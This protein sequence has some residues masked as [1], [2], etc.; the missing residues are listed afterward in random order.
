EEAVRAVPG[1]SRVTAVLTAQRKPDKA[2]ARDPH[3]M[4]KNPKLNLPVRHIIAVASG[5]GGVGKSTV[6]ANLAVSLAEIG[7][8]NGLKIGLLDA[9]IYGP[10]QPKMMGLEGRKPDFDKDGKIIP[11]D[12]YGLKVM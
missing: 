11:L 5:K 2:A 8:K 7:Q 6:A 9:D 12:A 3:G 1:V 4:E 10:S